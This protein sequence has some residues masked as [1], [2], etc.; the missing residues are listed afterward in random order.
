M[1]LNHTFKKRNNKNKKTQ[2]TQR[3]QKTQKTQ[4]RQKKSRKAKR[5]PFVFNYESYKSN[6][7]MLTTVWGPSL[8]HTLHTMSFNY[9]EKPTVTQQ[10]YYKRFVESLKY[11]LPCKYCRDNLR[12][13][14]K[15]HPITKS[16]MKNRH[17]FSL[18][19]YNLHETINRLLNKKSGL[20]YE[21]VRERYEHFRARCRDSSISKRVQRKTR[22][23]RGC[24]ESLHKF[25]SKGVVKIVPNDVKC[26]SIDIDTRC[27]LVV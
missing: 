11:T 1:K 15:K 2:K 4:N 14:L 21:D 13:N 19:I 26:S 16:V 27:N 8:W 9:P 25:K 12:E 17:S 5:V 24:T 3:T 6:D 23:H 18:Y 7:G 20:S 22:K 10:K